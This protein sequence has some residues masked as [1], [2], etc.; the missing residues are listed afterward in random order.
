VSESANKEDEQH[1]EAGQDMA[2]T[3][4]IAVPAPA[5]LGEGPVWDMEDARLWWVDIKGGLIH[6][7]DPASGDNGAFDFGEPVGCIARRDK[8][9]LIV[10]AASGFY[11]FDPE[12]GEPHGAC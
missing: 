8:G 10:A 4:D 6:C 12:T 11:L 2:V 3:V 7:F 5:R 1:P 9:G